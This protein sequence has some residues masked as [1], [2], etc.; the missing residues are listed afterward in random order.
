MSVEPKQNIWPFL[1]T[2][3]QEICWTSEGGRAGLQLWFISSCYFYSRFKHLSG[4]P[5]ANP[6]EI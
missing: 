3:L 2:S 4:L 6:R 5:S 1:A